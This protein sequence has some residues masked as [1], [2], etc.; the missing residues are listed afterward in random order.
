MALIRPASFSPR[1]IIIEEE[2]R[3]VGVTHYVR[4]AKLGL[5][6]HR[7]LDRSYP[8]SHH[9][10]AVIQENLLKRLSEIQ[11]TMKPKKDYRTPK[12]SSC[13]LEKSAHV[14]LG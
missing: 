4:P 9:L 5:S 13:S 10:C 6:S 1:L 12:D 3:R 14:V 11:R 2:T 7:G 8:V